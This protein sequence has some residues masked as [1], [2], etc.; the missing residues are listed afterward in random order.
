ME[1]KRRRSAVILYE[2]DDY[3]AIEKYKE[4][5]E[6]LKKSKEEAEQARF[7]VRGQTLQAWVKIVLYLVTVILTFVSI[8]LSVRSCAPESKQIPSATKVSA[9]TNEPNLPK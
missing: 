4:A 9:E 6:L 7:S 5:V 2:Q 8:I 3:S 1:E